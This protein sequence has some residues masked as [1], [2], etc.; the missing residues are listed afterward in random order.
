MEDRR[1]GRA[2]RVPRRDGARRRHRRRSKHAPCPAD[3]AAGSTVRGR[4]CG[5]GGPRA[6]TRSVH[7]PIQGAHRGGHRSGS[8]PTQARRGPA[9]RERQVTRT[10]SQL[11]ILLG[12]NPAAIT[13][14][15]PLTGQ[16]VPPSVP[17]GLPSALLEQR[18]DTRQAEATLVAAKRADRRGL[19]TGPSRIWQFGPT[20]TLQRRPEPGEPPADRG[21]AA[22]SASPLRAGHPAGVPRGRGRAR[23]Q[24]EGP[25]EVAGQDEAVRAS[26]EAL[27]IAELRYTSGLT[28]NLNVPRAGC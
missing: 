8:S 4:G 6:G 9:A 1:L 25:R 24:P 15:L 14:G 16:I 10:E 19:F 17:G 21:A 3:A 2:G 18:P 5:P 26:R 28:S 22:G 11:S 7:R 12:R 20:V 23:R 27:A 13:R